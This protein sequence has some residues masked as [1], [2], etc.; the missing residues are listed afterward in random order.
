MTRPV[1]PRRTLGRDCPGLRRAPH[2]GYLRS[3]ASRARV[4]APWEAGAVHLST[5]DRQEVGAGGCI[6]RGAAAGRV[7]VQYGDTLN[8]REPRLLGVLTVTGQPVGGVG[9]VGHPQPIW[10]VVDRLLAADVE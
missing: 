1:A 4:V 2:R 5:L 9:P 7:S 10:T 3:F 8:F 6:H